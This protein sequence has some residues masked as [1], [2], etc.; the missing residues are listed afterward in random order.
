ME[1]KRFFLGSN[2]IIASVRPSVRSPQPAYIDRQIAVGGKTNGFRGLRGA[3]RT[4]LRQWAETDGGMDG[5]MDD[6]SE[7]RIDA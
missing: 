3:E 4:G 2:R 5:W 6:V 1:N 7:S